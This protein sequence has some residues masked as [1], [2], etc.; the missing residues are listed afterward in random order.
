[1]ENIITKEL[2]AKIADARSDEEVIQI[3]ADAGMTLTLEQLH[4][5]QEDGELSEATL[6]AVNGGSIWNIVNKLWVRYKASQYN[7]GGGGFSSGGG[8]GGAGGGGGGGGGSR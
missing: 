2:E 7:G 8:G 4:A 3:F 1:M 6:E 5:Q